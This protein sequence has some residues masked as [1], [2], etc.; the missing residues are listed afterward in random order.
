VLFYSPDKAY[1]LDYTQLQIISFNPAS[2]EV[3]AALP[4]ETFRC[5]ELQTRFGFAVRR[6][7][8]FYFTRSCLDPDV[9]SSGST[10]VHLDPSTDE[11]TVTHDSR[12]M[13]MRVG[14]LADSGDAYWFSDPQASVEW[15]TRLID[16][17]HD[18]ALRLR[19]G[20]TTF[21]PDWELDLT[22]RTGGVSAIAAVPA[23]ASRIWMK[24]FEAS[25]M[26]EP[27]PAAQVNWGWQ[28]WRWALMDV[29][30]DAPLVPEQAAD[31]VVYY[32]DPITVD[33]RSFTP[34][35]NDDFSETTLVELTPAGVQNRLHVR[36]EL[37]EIVRLR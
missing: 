23:G 30:S 9:T 18:C 14:F 15:S 20:E 22:T 33:R 21:D 25:A 37:R 35:S 31:L 27:I 34:A 1:F 11:V 17:P 12:C 16:A 5:E 29:E 10:L 3:T 32:G 7:D 13:G 4:L 19:A 2:M 6:A 26:P 24:V 8:G 28:V 36:G